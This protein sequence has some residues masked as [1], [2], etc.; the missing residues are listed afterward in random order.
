MGN[1][2]AFFGLVRAG[3]CENEVRLLPYEGIDLVEV[4]RMTEEQLVV[5]LVVAG[6]EALTACCL[7]LAEKLML[8]GVWKKLLDE[9]AV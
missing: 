3:L 5:G 6:F 4:M 8:W 1:R 9:K 7:P 2:V